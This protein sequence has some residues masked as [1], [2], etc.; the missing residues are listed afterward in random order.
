M[1]ANCLFFVCGCVCAFAVSRLASEDADKLVNANNG[2][3]L[4]MT[5]QAGC[6][7]QKKVHAG[8]RDL[9]LFF[10]Y[11]P[12]ALF[13]F[14]ARVQPTEAEAMR[15]PPKSAETGV[16]RLGRI[17]IQAVF[18]PMVE[19]EGDIALLSALVWTSA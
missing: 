10:L 7:P 4:V 3:R 2:R 6:V 18:A 5:C 16:L 9:F 19:E 1:K 8:C 13:F 17:H 15:R 12:C 11:R 14:A